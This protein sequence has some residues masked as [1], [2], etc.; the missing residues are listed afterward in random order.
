MSDGPVGLG[1]PDGIRHPDHP[2]AVA[3]RLAAELLADRYGV[4]ASA[5][6]SSTLD[7]FSASTP[8][9]AAAEDDVS[10]EDTTATSELGASTGPSSS[11][12]SVSASRLSHADRL[13]A[14]RRSIAA[15]A[16]ARGISERKVLQQL[17][18]EEGIDTLRSPEVEFGK[19]LPPT[20][21]GLRDKMKMEEGD[22]GAAETMLAT[23]PSTKTVRARAQLHQSEPAQASEAAEFRPTSA[24][25]SASTNARKSPRV[26]AR[27]TPGRDDEDSSDDELMRALDAVIAASQQGRTFPRPRVARD[28]RPEEDGRRP[29]PPLFIDDEL[30]GASETAVPSSSAPWEGTTARREASLGPTSGRPRKVRRVDEVEEPPA[31]P[32]GPSSFSVGQ[33]V[34]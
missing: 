16:H 27:A 18:E 25:A 1:T 4:V 14:F 15:T 8:L 12:L 2:P 21:R 24:S 29:R 6:F 7:R 3:L 11:C 9:F 31:A 23:L 20:R 17:E 33:S 13:D 19:W 30:P 28:P 32:P 26:R 5:T 10:E 22:D 34:D